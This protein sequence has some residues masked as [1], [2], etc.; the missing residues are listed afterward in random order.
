MQR[1]LSYSALSIALIALAGCGGGTSTVPQTAALP[2]SKHAKAWMLPEAKGEVLLYATFGCAGT[3][4]ISYPAL[5]VVGSLPLAAA[6]VCSDAQGNVFFPGLDKVTEYAHGGTQPIATLNLPGDGA[7]A[8]A[9][10]PK[11]NDLAVV[12]EGNGGDVAVFADE[13]GAR[14]NFI[15]H[16]ASR[17]C[18]YDNNGNLFVDGYDGFG[19]GISELPKSA[20]TFRTFALPDT[21]GNPGRV[22]W[23]G[24][25]IAYQ[26]GYPVNA[27][28]RIAISGSTATVVETVNVKVPRRVAP[29]WFYDGKVIVPYNI[30]NVHPT[31][32]GVFKYP[33]GGAPTKTIR[34]YPPYKKATI[35]FNGVTVSVAP[36]N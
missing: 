33:K 13:H 26:G 18:G 17:S 7:H 32:I 36:S 25:Y 21:V 29:S 31:V 16:L 6:G 8:C 1:H 2:Q 35:D 9:V 5:Q 14:A 4:V 19:Y 23:D 22:Q 3:C 24:T 34:N 27:I 12:Y 10:D 28:S 30:H 11:S 15:S 20:S